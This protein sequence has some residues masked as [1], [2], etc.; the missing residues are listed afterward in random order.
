MAHV[1]EVPRKGSSNGIAYEVHWRLPG[2][3]K[4]QQTFTVKREAERFALRVESDLGDGQTTAPLMRKSK[5]FAQVTEAALAA[6]AGRLK[7][8]TQEGYRQMLDR[9]VLPT[10]GTRRIASITSANLE[11]WIAQLTSTQKQRGGSRLHPSTVRHAF[12]AA[13]KVFRYALRHRMIVHN[14]ATGTEL[15]RVQHTEKFAPQFLSGAEVEALAEALSGS[16]PDDLLVRVGAYCG[17]RAG[18]LVALR[19]G[20]VDVH[21]GRI[22]VQRTL[23]RTPDGWIEDSPKS[24]NSTRTVPMTKELAAL[25]RDYLAAHPHGDDLGAPLWPGR[26]YAGGGEWRGA[27]DWS[28]RLDYDSFYR[29][30][31]RV[32]AETIGR[33]TLR[34]HDLRHTAASLWAMHGMAMER[35]AAALGHADTGITYKTY[36]HFFPDQWDADMARFSAGLASPSARVTP[37]QREA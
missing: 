3:K 27:L 26:N 16:A 11:Q 2:G 4:V 23:V 7:V 28:K 19:V 32:A 35:V 13:N 15:P 33:P 36:L 30:R 5:T 29:R 31:F 17:L 8:R 25:L 34:F 1:R 6:S 18:E 14:P 37:L 24:A 10:F 22:R 21:R 20:D 12:I 9:H